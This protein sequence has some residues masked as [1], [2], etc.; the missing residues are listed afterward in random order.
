MN[1]KS[2]QATRM[3]SELSDLTPKYYNA[4][5]KGLEAYTGAAG[6]KPNWIYTTPD[7]EEQIQAMV[8]RHE[9]LVKKVRADYRAYVFLTKKENLKSLE[10]G[11]PV[12]DPTPGPTPDETDVPF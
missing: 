6:Q 11:Q 12:P 7:N 4:E 10:Q 8:N 3:A 2:Q 1:D 5:L 9:S